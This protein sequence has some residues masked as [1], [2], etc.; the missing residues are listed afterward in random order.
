MTNLKQLAYSSLGT[1]G[2]VA[3]IGGIAVK[4]AQAANIPGTPS[5][6]GNIWICD[7][8][9]AGECLCAS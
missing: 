2:V 3:S 6:V 1:L 4:T 9:K 8:T 5:F 7:C